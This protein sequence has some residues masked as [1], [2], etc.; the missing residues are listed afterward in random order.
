M[1]TQN[2]SR[3]AGFTLIELMIVLSVMAVLLFVVAPSFR[4]MMDVRRVRGV[5]DQFVTDV[6]FARSEAAGRQ[7][8]VG[9]SFKPPGAATSCYIVHTCG[10]TPANS[11]KCN[12]AAAPGSRCPDPAIVPDPPREIR[13]VQLADSRVSLLPVLA[14][15]NPLPALGAGTTSIAFDPTTGAMTVFYGFGLV[16]GIPPAN[17]AFWARVSSTTPGSSTIVRDVVNTSG[18]PTICKPAGS[19]I[20][21]ITSC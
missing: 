14:N 17:G 1:R 13:T 9:I 6:Q 20:T 21:G 11:C 18:R 3:S 19:T 12:C 8:I 2:N 7:E 10:S 16:V 15:G 4:E 5:S